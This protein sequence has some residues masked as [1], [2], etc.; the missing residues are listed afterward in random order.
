LVASLFGDLNPN[1]GTETEIADNEP[2]LTISGARAVP[3]S[4]RDEKIRVANEVKYKVLQTNKVVHLTRPS[5]AQGSVEL[6]R[7][8]EG[9]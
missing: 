9:R 3:R 1:I 5:E 6:K 2:M 7:F 8:K 4:S